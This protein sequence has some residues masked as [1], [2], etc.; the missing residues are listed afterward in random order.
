MSLR[1]EIIRILNQYLD[2]VKISELPAGTTPSGNEFIEVVQGGTS[3]RLTVSQVSSGGVGVLS[4]VAGTN[5]TVDN[6]DPQ[7]PIV[8]STGGGG[9]G[10]VTSVS[11]TGGLISVA[12]ATT[13][14]A[15]TVAG[16]SGGIP[17]FSSA[18][19][20]AS[21]GALAANALMIG[22]GAGAAPSTTT[23]GTGVLTFLGTPSWT[24]FNSMITGTAP[25]WSLASGGTLT[26]V[27]TITSNAHSQHVFDGTWIANA[28]N[29]NHWI[30]NPVITGRASQTGDMVRAVTISPSFTAGTGSNT[31]NNIALN[32]QPS[33]NDNGT[34]GAIHSYIRCFDGTTARFQVTDT[35]VTIASS[36]NT[37]TFTNGAAGPQLTASSGSL[38]LNGSNVLMQVSG[39]SWFGVQSSNQIGASL[40]AVSGTVS[41]T[42]TQTSSRRLN[43]QVGE[44]TGSASQT[45]YWTAKATQST[46]TNQLS[47]WDLSFGTTGSAPSETNLYMRVRNTDGN[48][49]VGATTNTS[50][51]P[52]VTLDNVGG[53]ATRHTT[54]SQI[55]ADQNDYAIGVQTAF[56][57]SSDASRNVT[58]LTGGVDGK[59]LIISNV[60]AQDIVFTHED[61]ASTAANRITSS[62]GANI[63]VSGGHT[64]TFIY[65][66]TTSRWRDIAFR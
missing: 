2:A 40:F 66:A 13:T 39:S 36:S 31:T 65:D 33:W 60:G 42:A 44:W 5:V 64:I 14:P 43:W 52:N 49:L 21:S 4:V 17:Y 55:T 7:N 47:Y 25:F 35:N 22:G 6:T 58:G 12:N 26:G 37:L 56:R 9:S 50:F 61:A 48:I 11:F 54:K 28:N 24:N 1:G 16:T 51:T 63:T 45:N 57:M 32:I 23:T 38:Q 27:N 41:S 62:T 10:T 20:W 18:S 34:S 46:A 8:S 15:L 30:W 59:W 29:Q 53:M 3:V 19:T